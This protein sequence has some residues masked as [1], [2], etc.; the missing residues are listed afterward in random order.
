MD[1]HSRAGHFVFK[2]LS[3]SLWGPLKR[4]CLALPPLVC[5]ILSQKLVRT[6]L[7]PFTTILL[8]RIVILPPS[9]ILFSL[10]QFILYLEVF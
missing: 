10:C 5:P 6:W 2:N 3:V 8:D 4:G 7:Q 9:M 1:D